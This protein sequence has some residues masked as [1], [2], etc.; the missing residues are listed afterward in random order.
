MKTI[1]LA[2]ALVALPLAALAQ[3]PTTS[4]TAATNSPEASQSA[5]APGRHHDGFA[6]W[7]TNGD[8]RISRE[9][10]QA[11]GAAMA[12]KR[13]DR[14]DLNKDGVVTRDEVQQARADHSAAL[15]QKFEARFK[16]A[17]TNGAGGLSKAEMTAA[18]PRLARHFDRLDTNKDGIVTLDE[19]QVARQHWR[20]RARPAPSGAG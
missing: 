16:A 6:Q 8:G 5:A 15:Q 7:D 2:A 14:V 17:D 19:V 1:A 12:L 9:E 3:E 20:S 11:A 13:F 10:A 18:F 4:P